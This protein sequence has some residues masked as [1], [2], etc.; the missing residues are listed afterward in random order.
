MSNDRKV[1]F[2][3]Y[4]IGKNVI[5]NLEEICS[6]YGNNIVVIGGQTALD[7]MYDKL[8]GSVQGTKLEIVDCLWYGG[9]CT[10]ANIELLTKKALEKQVN[11]ILG[12]GGGK[13]IDTA[14]G[15]AFKLGIPVIT[16]PTIAS[17]CAGITSLSVVY[18]EN[19]DFDSFYFFDKPPVHCIID[20]DIIAKAPVKYLR[21]GMGD[22]MAKH[23]ECTFSSRGAKLDHSSN[24]AKEISNMCVNPLITYGEKAIKDCHM[25]VNSFEVE[26]VILNNIV[27]TGLVSMLIDEKYNGALAHSLFYG[28]TILEHIEKNYLHG[29][30]VAYGVLVQL[31]VDNNY[32]ELS[33]LYDFYRKINLPTSLDDIE[34]QYDRNYLKEVLR[35]TVK[36]PDMEDLP[37][38]ITE[39]MVFKAIGEVEQLK[40]I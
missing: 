20:S 2:P 27:S 10:Y 13:A 26:Q 21:A 3:N 25:N 6:L 38:K 37:Y 40:K 12:V 39:E 33:K 7:K 30:V 15:V 22:T 28:L 11:V 34:V 29:D 18:K 4:S 1:V 8:Q 31:A 35:N 5:N 9:E 23:Y 16:L 14:K 36:G 32:K 19:G 24:L 17:T